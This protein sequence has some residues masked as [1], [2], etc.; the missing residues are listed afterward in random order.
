MNVTDSDEAI[1]EVL[2]EGRATPKMLI[3]WTGLS[4]PTVHARLNVLIATGAVEKIHDSGVYELVN[5]PRDDRD[6]D[7]DRDGG[8]LPEPTDE[9]QEQPGFDPAVEAAAEAENWADN[10]ERLEARKKAAQA[11]LDLLQER[12][13][14]DKST[15]VDVLFEDYSVAGQNERTWYRKNIRPVLNEAAEYDPSKRAYRLANDR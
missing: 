7:K 14:V 11:A 13:A 12:G 5:D 8:N 4:K 1:L 15:F 10:P 2:D 3:D 9:R 6:D